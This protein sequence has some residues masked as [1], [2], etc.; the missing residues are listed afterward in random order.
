MHE[1]L[2]LSGKK[3][4]SVFADETGRKYSMRQGFGA[5]RLSGDSAED[6]FRPFDEGF[7][8]FLMDYLSEKYKEEIS[9]KLA[10]NEEVDQHYDSYP[11]RDIVAKIINKISQTN[12]I[13]RETVISEFEK[14]YFT[15]RALDIFKK[16]NKA[17]G[18][19]SYEVLKKLTMNDFVRGYSDEFHLI[20][21]YFGDAS[22]E[23]RN[24]IREKL[25]K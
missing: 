20:R 3:S 1:A 11:T 25:F 16:I 21:D 7:V 15:G 19:G 2:H 24:K 9:N 4:F 6:F 14:S 18:K 10:L 17:Y 5:T 23:E 8:D 13:S 12:N 22:E